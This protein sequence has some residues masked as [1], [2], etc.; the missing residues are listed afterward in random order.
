MNSTEMKTK[1]LHY[2]RFNR[3]YYYIATEV[4]N[5]NADVLCSNGKEIVECEVK[6]SYA[7]FLNDFKRKVNKHEIYS[8]VTRWGASECPTKFYFAVAND[9]TEKVKKYL[10]DSP[11]GVIEISSIELTS[12]K[13]SNRKVIRYCKIIK[14]AKKLHGFFDERLHNKIIMRSGSELI[15]ARL[16]LKVPKLTVVV[17]DNSLT[18]TTNSKLEVKNEL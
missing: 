12:F 7:D 5:F 8:N 1:L 14:Q 3:K 9:L 2:W 16:T 17:S 6:T 13:T 4:G 11:Y 10:E 18:I 15:R